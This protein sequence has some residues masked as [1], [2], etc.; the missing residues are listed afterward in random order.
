MLVLDALKGL[1]SDE[2]QRLKNIASR[3]RGKVKATKLNSS[4]YGTFRMIVEAKYPDPIKDAR[5]GE[6]TRI[7]SEGLQRRVG[8]PG[9]V[10]AV[11]QRGDGKSHPAIISIT[12][13]ETALD[14]VKRNLNS[15]LLKL[16]VKIKSVT[17]DSDSGAAYAFEATLPET[18]TDDEFT[19]CVKLVESELGLPSFYIRKD[20]RRRIFA[21]S[22]SV[23]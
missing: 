23:K 4:G 8:I 1:S 9:V 13:P 17:K 10:I 21:S 22:S 11:L 6:V 18:I 3:F 16:E 19:A 15:N 14:T 2:I 20:I 7:D 5:L 12:G